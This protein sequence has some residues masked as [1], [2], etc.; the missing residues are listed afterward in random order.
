MIKKRRINL[1]INRQ[2]YNIYEEYF[3]LL[4]KIVFVLF[5]LFFIL[6]FY[7]VFS[8]NKLNDE[9]KIL[10]S[11]KTNLLKII[12]QNAEKYAKFNYLKLKYYDLKTFLKDDAS[13]SY[14]YSLLKEAL[15][16]SSE[17]AMIKEFIINKNRD[18]EFTI[19][20][21][22]F[23]DLRNF[24]KFIE[25]ENFLKNFEKIFL[26]NFAVIGKNETKEENYELSFYGRFLPYEVLLKKN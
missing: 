14:Y 7:F 17:S 12:N 1:I 4:R 26:K 8:I 11:E 6:F 16:E 24:F 18:F 23:S 22:S 2:D 9:L 5:F 19:G 3:F 21:L 25:S 10:N 13:S 20:F 15:N